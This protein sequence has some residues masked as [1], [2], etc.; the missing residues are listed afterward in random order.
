M[1]AAL[2]STIKI[3]GRIKDAS[4]NGIPNV[5]V[6]LIGPRGTVLASTTDAEGSYSFVVS[7]SQRGY[8]VIPS[9][10]GVT[11]EPLDKVLVGLSDDQKE[12]DFVGKQAREP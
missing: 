4:N 1:A 5:V 9:K 10:D 8:R 12:L 6:V 2:R 11:F 7:R 3:G